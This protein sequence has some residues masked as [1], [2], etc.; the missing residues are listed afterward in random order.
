MSTNYSLH[1]RLLPRASRPDATAPCPV[2]SAP[3]TFVA[4]LDRFVHSDG[5][6]NRDCW[7]VATLGEARINRRTFDDWYLSSSDAV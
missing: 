2:C 1:P 4:S 7:W 5:S 6:S 3:A